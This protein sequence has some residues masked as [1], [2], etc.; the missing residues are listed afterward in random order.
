[1]KTLFTVFVL[2]V[3]V[4]VTLS[5]AVPSHAASIIVESGAVMLLDTD[6]NDAAGTGYQQGGFTQ[7]SGGQ[8]YGPNVTD[9]L[10]F[11][12]LLGGG[13]ADN[14]NPWTSHMNTASFF[15]VPQD[16]NDI[17]VFE[18]WIQVPPITNNPGWPSAAIFMRDHPINRE[19]EAPDFSFQVHSWL[20]GTGANL[21]GTHADRLGLSTWVWN[22]YEDTGI[23]YPTDTP[24]GLRTIMIPGATTNELL[25][26]YNIAGE[27]QE[28][29]P[30]IEALKTQSRTATDQTPW[31][32]GHQ[33]LIPFVSNMT[34]ENDSLFVDSVRIFTAMLV[35]VELSEFQVE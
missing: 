21:T 10:G 33:G 22:N 11:M 28:Y 17:T 19:S 9:G 7:W 26:E 3:G 12:E 16:S 6:C 20:I 5:L 18:Y 8:P 30:A 31:W 14:G 35:P 27:W 23:T 2:F 13:T 4:I 34:G 29:V 24:F 15:A 1:M 32:Q 25:Y